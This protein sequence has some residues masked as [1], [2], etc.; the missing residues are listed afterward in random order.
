[1][2]NL[3]LCLSDRN[4][5][6]ILFSSVVNLSVS[7][8]TDLILL[9][10]TVVLAGCVFISLVIVKLQL[11]NIRVPAWMGVGISHR[12]NV[13]SRPRRREASSSSAVFRALEPDLVP[14]PMW[15][16]SNM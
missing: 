12:F 7:H 10:D 4:I 8:S 11:Y 14:W 2:D 1:M 3:T 5:M 13:G 15:R 9:K 6:D 16:V